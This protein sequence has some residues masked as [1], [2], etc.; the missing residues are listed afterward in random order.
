MNLTH[1]TYI[2]IYIAI[3]IIFLICRYVVTN[4]MIVIKIFYLQMNYV[5]RNVH[6][7]F[8]P[9]AS[10]NH[11]YI[12]INITRKMLKILQILLHKFYKLIW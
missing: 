9:F 7:I 8:L 1:N 4:V 5:I 10:L 2:H 3:Y 12:Y 6:K 11:K